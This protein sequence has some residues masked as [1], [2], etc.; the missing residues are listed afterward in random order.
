M[1]K[2]IIGDDYPTY[3]ESVNL[4]LKE[5]E[6]PSDIIWCVSVETQHGVYTILIRQEKEPTAAELDEIKNVFMHNFD[7]EEDQLHV[8]TECGMR[9][10]SELPTSVSEYVRMEKS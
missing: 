10:I 6:Q 2:E 4:T 3:E 9:Y 7:M 5:R 8:G 1:N